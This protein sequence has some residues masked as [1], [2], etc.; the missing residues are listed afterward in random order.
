[1]KYEKL[2]NLD[3]YTVPELIEQARV[4]RELSADLQRDLRQTKYDDGIPFEHV[5]DER[6][7]TAVNRLLQ[8]IMYLGF[9]AELYAKDIE[10]EIERR[11]K[12][13]ELLHGICDEEDLEVPAFLAG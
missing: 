9:D 7:H 3:L 4:L 13:P 8:E 2:E 12:L 11:K 6:S 10:K 1:M 5:L